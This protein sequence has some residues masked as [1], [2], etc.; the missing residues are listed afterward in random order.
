MR[1]NIIEIFLFMHMSIVGNSS[2]QPKAHCNICQPTLSPYSH[3]EE[4]SVIGGV[5]TQ[6]RYKCF[7]VLFRVFTEKAPTRYSTAF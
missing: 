4:L 1:R 6:N 7:N 3:G 2:E 5:W